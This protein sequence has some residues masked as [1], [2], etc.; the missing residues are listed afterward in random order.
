MENNIDMNYK[1][2]LIFF[3]K[4]LLPISL[5][6]FFLLKSTIHIIITSNIDNK[7]AEI[8][9]SFIYFF[10]LIN[11]T[12]TIYPIS[13]SDEEKHEKKKNKYKEDKS[14]L[15][16]LNLKKIEL[17]NLIVLYR[18]IR[19]VRISEI[20]SNLSY[21]SE[22]IQLTS[23]IY[24]LVNMIYGNISN[25]FKSDKMYLKVSPCYN[26]NFIKYKGILHV[27]P[28]VKDI[29]IFLKGIIYIYFKI[30][31]YKKV[32]YGKEARKD[33]IDKLYKRPNGHN[34]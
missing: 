24:V 8:K 28:T 19:K 9:I 3:I 14:R 18:I 23:F 27:S 26:Q 25:Y 2:L 22:N 15:K 4:I 21:G 33:E 34:A 30:R 16:K 32:K 31:Q 10:N 6:V 7:D 29:I 17:E 20:Y 1:D 11:I 13:K 5:I 12:K